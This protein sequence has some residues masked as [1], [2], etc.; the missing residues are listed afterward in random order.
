MLKLLTNIA[1]FTKGILAFLLVFFLFSQQ[2]FA[3]TGSKVKVF[4]NDSQG[5]VV[6]AAVVVK[7]TDNAAITD[8]DGV[9][10]LLQVSNDA[11]LE[12]S[13]LG[14]QTAE[15]AVA[16]KS[17]ITVTLHEDSEFLE[18]VVVV[19]YGTMKKKDL[20][21]AIQSADLETF[22]NAPNP[23]I[24]ESLHGTVPG[25][26]IG[27]VNQAGQEP[28]IE[29]RG[30]ITINGSKNPLIVLDGA[31]YPG[32]ISDLNPDDIQSI[33][34]L[35]DASSKAVYGAS[36]ANGVLL[37]TSKNGGRDRAPSITYG[38]SFTYSAPT[39]KTRP[40]NR[41]EYIEY[42]KDVDY[43]NAFTAES[44]YLK[45][46]P[47]WDFS[48][49]QVMA[50]TREG[51]QNGTEYDWWDAA[52]TKGHLYNHTISISGGSDKVSYYI[53]G[54]NTDQ[55]AIVKNDTYKRNTLRA[56]IDVT[57][58]KWLKAG[59]N[60]FLAFADFSG[61]C[62]TLNDILN[63]SPVVTPKDAD[64]NWNIN[65]SGQA[66]LN[67]FLYMQSNDV[68]KRFQTN[69]LL[70]AQV[71]FPFL[72]GLQYRV[73]YNYILSTNDQ[74]N[75]N[76]FKGSQQ[77][78]AQKNVASSNSWLLDNI[79]SYNQSFGRHT[80]NAT[81]VYGANA[82]NYD[83]TAAQAI[84][85]ATSIL[86]FNNLQ[87]G[88]TPKIS[89]SAWSQSSL[90]QMGR[91][92][93]NYDGRY[94]FTATVRR[95]GFSGF[96]EGH[97]FGIF[98]SV[99]LSWVISRENFFK[100]NWIDLLKIRASYG[101][102]GNQ[103]DRYSSLARI[104]NSA[105]YVFGDGA[106]TTVGTSVSSMANNDLKWETTDELNAGVDF[107][108]FHSRLSGSIDFYHSKTHDLIWNM[109][110]P[111]VTGFSSVISNVGN[112]QNRGVEIMLIG[113]PVQTKD[114][115][116]TISAA[117]SANKNKVVS[118]LGRD[119][120]GDGKEDDLVSSGLFIGEPIGTIY[121]YQ[122][123]GVWQLDDKDI[124]AGFSPGTYKI[125][126]FNDDGKISAAEDRVILGHTEPAFRLGITNNLRYKNFNLSFFINT[127][128]GGKN[129][130]MAVNN[131]KSEGT[132]GNQQNSNILTI[133]KDA[134]WSP[135]NPEGTI[136]CL[137][138][139]PAV[140]AQRYQQRSFV[141][142]QDISLSYDFD[143]PSLKK[144]G[145]KHLDVFVSGKNLLTFTKWE[146][147]DPE[148]AQGLNS[149]SYPVMKSFAAGLNITL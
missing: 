118:L 10:N 92:A 82:K 104:S 69:T 134:L 41:E 58:N 102:T 74:R 100:V 25:L 20:T 1:R 132:I 15:V 75:F 13:C 142:L 16:G 9:A 47:N 144:I 33:D 73:N 95:D 6:G 7:T 35:K 138:H 44:G 103:V 55:Q 62:A 136:Q 83:Y 51:L 84:G 72:R 125:H 122:I 61:E 148:T 24:M 29:V 45:E 63:V 99:G 53:S 52:T 59:T 89:S 64:G 86:G 93:Y 12:I 48:L 27:Q 54:S 8:I 23:T 143:I 32:R 79:L 31:I 149:A 71:D 98:P 130:Y 121:T 21:G 22:K 126:D 114:F 145:I 123:D 131:G 135:R 11:I 78:Q 80:V 146:G 17:E 108:F 66:L 77:G 112:I 68:D 42:I 94:Y 85:F 119:N 115:D 49:T 81:F 91:I 3:Q 4:V 129:G 90:Y 46:N 88:E 113:K 70:Y 67:P 117:F 128:Q 76:E 50:P 133:Q 5:P 97:K 18:E 28:S 120:D 87:M 106:S 36:A 111:S 109:S 38:N 14:Y 107:E 2:S 141:R 60:T 56:N 34:V 139:N 127:I 140:T 124:M 40:L 105:Y 57:I 137:W 37:I 147:W 110:I 101:R 26:N 65:P 43:K 39:I 116:W 30:Q 19:G 96:S